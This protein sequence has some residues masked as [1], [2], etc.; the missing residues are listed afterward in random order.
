MWPERRVFSAAKKLISFDLIRIDCIS[1][2]LAIPPGG[3]PSNPSK[4]ASLSMSLHAVNHRLTNIPVKQLPPIASCLA[5]SLSNCGELLSS[6]QQQ[7]SAKSDSEDAVQVHRLMTR[8]TSLLQDRTPE[9]RWTAVVLVK[10]VVEA[11]QWEVLRGCEPFVRG[12]MAI[13]TVRIYPLRFEKLLILASRWLLTYCLGR[14]PILLPP[15]KWQSS[16]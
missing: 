14:K 8:L 7:K 4:M 2:S 16:P 3:L 11:G 1:L 13:L 6:P 12:L 15:R 5:T 9:G 10:A